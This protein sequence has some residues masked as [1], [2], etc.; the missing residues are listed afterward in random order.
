[1]GLAVA[2]VWLAVTRYRD[3]WP[4]HALILAFIALS[5]ALSTFDLGQARGWFD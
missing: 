4:R 5:A 3:A 1:M 2:A